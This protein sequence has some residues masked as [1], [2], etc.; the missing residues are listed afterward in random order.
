[1]KQ[2][3]FD[4]IGQSRRW[5]IISATLVLVALAGILLRGLN[6][7]ID[8]S[9]GTSF[10]VEGVTTDAS[11]GEIS[12][13]VAAAGGSDVRVQLVTDS[14]GQDGALIRMAAID[15]D[16]P[17]S[18]DVEAAIAEVTGSDDIEESFVGPTWGDEISRKAV[19]ALVVFLIVV[20]LYIS[21]RLAAKMAGAAIVALVHD[22][23]LVIGVYAW[24]QFPVSPNTVIALL[25]ILGYSLYDTVVV[26]DRVEENATYLGQPG[27]RTYA[28][29]VNTSQN[30]VLWRSINTSVTSLL[31]VGA[32]L[33]IGS[34]LLGAE[35]LQDLALALFLGMA[36]GTY[37]SLF[38][39]GPF[40]AWWVG[41]EPAMVDLTERYAGKDEEV[42]APAPEA[43][44]AARR[45]ITTEYVRG[46]G[47]GKRRKR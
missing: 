35:T 3:R 23:V 17:V 29:L 30:E 14:E 38:V 45:P 20:V 33:L 43:A 31:P 42:V 11:P 1:M 39:A 12:D 36:F 32:L 6:L 9:G 13:A 34:Q 24:F 47:K 19:E 40:L 21:F 18:D 16:G 41:R 15:I 28:Q 2:P 10:A 27:R 26:F 46:E 25:T 4:F 44:A 7:S 8:F 22:V 37:S 5:A